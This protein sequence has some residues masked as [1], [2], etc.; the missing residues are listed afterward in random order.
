MVNDFINVIERAIITELRDQSQLSG[1]HIF[2]QY[3]EAVDVAYPAIVLELVGSGIE[4][5][6]I[7]LGINFVAPFSFVNGSNAIIKRY[8][9]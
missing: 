4:E 5:K 8:K 1:V 6:F 3:P 2:G 9:N 7:D